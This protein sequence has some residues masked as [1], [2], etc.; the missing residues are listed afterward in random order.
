MLDIFPPDPPRLRVDALSAQEA[1]DYA[2]PRMPTRTAGP[3]CLQPFT[4]SR[5]SVNMAEG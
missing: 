1:S 5:R 4:A 3:D 2:W